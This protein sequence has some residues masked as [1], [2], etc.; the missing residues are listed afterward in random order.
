MGKISLSNIIERLATK[1]GLSREASD[2]FMHAFVET[3]ERGLQEDGIVKIKGLGTFKLQ[4]VNDRES[5]DVNTGERITIKGYRRVTFTPDIIMKEFINRPFAHFE[6]TELNDGYPVDEETAAPD[7]LSDGNEESG[8][9]VVEEPV[10]EVEDNT[11]PEIVE[12]IVEKTEDF[13][14]DTNVVEDEV[15]AI[16]VAEEVLPEIIETVEE[17]VENTEEDIVAETVEEETVRETVEGIVE[18]NNI[19]EDTVES[20]EQPV[21]PITEEDS[22]PK[23]VRKKRRGGYLWFFLLFLI[24]FAAYTLCT[25]GVIFDDPVCDTEVDEQTDI[26]VKPNLQEVLG[27]EL[28]DMPESKAQQEKDVVK[29]VATESE[30]ETPV[31]EQP[32]SKVPESP[33]PQ[34]IE[35]AKPT[36]G[37]IF[38]EVKLIEPLASKPLKEIT[39]SD[40]ADY[41]IEG[42]LVTHELK[43]G[44]TIIQLAKRYYGEKRLWPYIVKHNQM[45]DYNN[46]AI[47]QRIDIPILK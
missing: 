22:Q 28:E 11:I 30:P 21:E 34:E 16:S 18:E 20:T 15:E 12:E 2:N 38:C 44:E 36:T 43:S 9:T 26:T 10:T 17:T 8:I 7:S 45:K 27:A 32:Q 5:V 33:Q 31:I 19:E 42:T 1:S 41:T 37:S 14:E 3:I 4:E 40:T 23:R 39:L 24:A 25:H 35:P 46:L 29:P 13:V 47:G 6:P